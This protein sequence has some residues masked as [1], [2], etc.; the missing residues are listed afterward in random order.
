MEE[1]WTAESLDSLPL[2]TLVRAYHAVVQGFTQM[3]AEHQLS[4]VQFGVLAQLAASP[5]LTQAELARRVLV[6]PQSMAELIAGLVE[7][8][9]LVRDGP[10]GRGRALPVRLSASGRRLL[11]R[12]TAAV[13]EFN[14]PRSLDMDASEAQTLNSLLHKVIQSRGQY[15]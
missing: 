11:S 6:R 8:G 9:L 3:F 2:W 1:Q 4:P 12:A 14:A 13:R 15:P 5:G 7:R 10:G